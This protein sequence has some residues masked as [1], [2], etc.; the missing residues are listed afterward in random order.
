[1][2]VDNEAAIDQLL[3]KE[4]RNVS[5]LIRKAD[6][7]AEAGEDKTANAFYRSAL[8]VV[9]SGAP[10]NASQNELARAQQAIMNLQRRFEDYLQDSLAQA[11]FGE[12]KRPPR[13]AEAIDILLGRRQ[14]VSQL[15]NPRALFYPGLPQR[16]YYERNEFPWAVAL[17]AET[18]AIR[19][20]LLP[21]MGQ[22]TGFKPYIYSDPS[23]PPKHGLVDNP[24]WSSLNLWEGSKPIPE[25]IAKCPHTAEVIQKVDLLRLEKRAPQVMF[26]KLAGGAD[27]E[28]HVGLLNI[29]LVCH[30]PIIVPDGCVFR[31]GGE[32]RQWHEGELLTFDD[33]I[34]HE[35]SNKGDRDRVVLIFEIWRPE[36][37]EDEREAITALFSAVDN[38]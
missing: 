35:A 14:A 38:Y 16:R 22:D 36:L 32:D 1:M 5:A 11:G 19:E 18:D 26:S 7:R 21:L 15:Q 33:S 2:L 6:F 8:K 34:L 23:R 17:E 37:D 25:N 29:R 28:P 12:G 30:L 31:V 9:A 24:D 20:E 4:P 27:I 3:A 10:S 13:F